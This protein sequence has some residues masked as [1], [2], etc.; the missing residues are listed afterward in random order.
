M[1]KIFLSA[2][3]VLSVLAVAYLATLGCCHLVRAKSGSGAWSDRLGL[4]AEQRKR[5]APLEEA[6]ARQRGASCE[7][8]CV[9]RAQMIALLKQA[10]PD[11]AALRGL[12]EEIGAEQTA[13]EKATL[14][15]ILAVAAVL[16]PER[17][18]KLIAQVSEELRTACRETACGSS[19]HCSIAGKS[20]K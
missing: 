7:T 17:R 12:I 15:H 1:K 18:E 20:S 11:R 6:F 14:D 13:L 3:L 10:E 5:V 16:E 4:T 2:G 9:K 8:L 19:G